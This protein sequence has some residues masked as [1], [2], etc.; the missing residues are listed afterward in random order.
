M[1]LII[2]HGEDVCMLTGKQ[3]RDCD[4]NKTGC[5]FLIK[6]EEMKGEKKER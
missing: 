1:I 2:Y 6:H 4:R 3:C 5:P